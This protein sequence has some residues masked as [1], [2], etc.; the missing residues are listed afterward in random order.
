[1]KAV[2]ASPGTYVVKTDV[3]AGPRKIS[4]A[5]LNDHVEPDDPSP[6]NRDRNLFVEHVEVI[7]PQRAKAKPLQD[8]HRQIIPRQ[9]TGIDREQLAREIL[10]TLATRAYRRP[11]TPDDINRLI[12][13][14]DLAVEHGDSFERGIQLAVQ[15]ILVSP[16]F[17]FRVELDSGSGG[18][19][20]VT[21]I[22]EYELASRLSYFLWSSMP[23]D[24]LFV[25]ARAGT[26]RQNLDGQVRRMLGD[27]KSRALVENFGLQWLQ[28]RN[29]ATATP[30]AKRFPAFDEMLRADMLRETTL[31]LEHVMR[32]D[33]SVLELLD[34][35]YTFV[36]DRLAE[37]YGIAGVTGDKFRRVS[38]AGT[39]RSGLLTQASVLTVTSNPTR[40]SPVKR[41]RWVL[42]QLLGAPPAPPPP[43]VPELDEPR[44]GD[45]AGTLRERMQQHRADPNCATCHARMDPLGF[46]LENFDAIGA[47]RDRDAGRPIDASGELPNGQKFDGPVE[48]KAVLK[49]RQDLFCRCLAQKMFTYAVGRGT[50]RSDEPA[51]DAIVAHMAE[52]EFSFSSLV[53]GIVR[54]E[55][56]QSRPVNSVATDD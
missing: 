44:D 38:L 12:R 7:G 20:P 10:G 19:G 35:N 21:P 27:S 51:I 23:D 28:L 56:F 43:N 18:V 4:V 45:S 29:L 49:S 15:A 8:G 6:E 3:A 11:A 30:D 33:R 53:L 31:F 54:S 42:E 26:L 55:S 50:E 22:S 17:L 41:G 1:V 5:F 16:H 14:I 48:L 39:P 32:A 36:N 37:H 34:A 9:P 24:E 2:E 40:T 13:F 47:W 46:G 52:N 25:Q